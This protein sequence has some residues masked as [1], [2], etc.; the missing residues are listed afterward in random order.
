MD[1]IQKVTQARGDLS[2]VALSAIRTA[3]QQ[4]QVRLLTTVG[5]LQKLKL[6]MTTE[7]G[8]PTIANV[9]LS[10]FDVINQSLSDIF[11]I[12]NTVTL[13]MDA[14][15]EQHNVGRPITDVVADVVSMIKQSNPA[16]AHKTEQEIRQEFGL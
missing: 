4:A 10:E 7:D 2:V 6:P 13:E 14:L 16:Y 3:S 9:L 8:K 15:A 1:E 12:A 11:A 5:R